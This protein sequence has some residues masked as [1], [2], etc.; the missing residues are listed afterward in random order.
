MN[1]EFKIDHI[2]LTKKSVSE[3]M[4]GHF[5]LAKWLNILKI[6]IAKIGKIIFLSF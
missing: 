4:I 5:F 2:S 6:E 3:E 1:F